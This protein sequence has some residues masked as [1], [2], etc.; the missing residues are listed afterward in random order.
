MEIRELYRY[1]R[2]QGKVTV[3]TE[4][5]NCEYTVV[6]R[7]IASE[8]HLVTQDGINKYSVIDT[9]T[10][11]GWYEVEEPKEEVESNK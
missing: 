9:D 1:E 6:Y 3:S 10:K 5:P 8:N 2:E 4:K 11:D 7:I